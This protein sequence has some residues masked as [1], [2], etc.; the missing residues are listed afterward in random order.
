M[1]TYLHS[2]KGRQKILGYQTGDSDLYIAFFSANKVMEETTHLHSSSDE[3]Y[4]TT[5]GKGTIWV[6]G[7]IYR[8]EPGIV[9]KVE[10][11]EPHKVLSVYGGELEYIAI[12]TNTVDDKV[13]LETPPELL[14]LMKKHNLI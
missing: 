1:K 2:L 6:N 14:E 13:E 10:K 8:L 9:R 4:V 12:K 11:D 7:K 5:K 3:I